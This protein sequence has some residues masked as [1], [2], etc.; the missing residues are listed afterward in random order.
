M[1]HDAFF[2]VA[3]DNA[4][5]TIAERVQGRW[6]AILDSGDLVLPG[7]ALRKMRWCEAAC[8]GSRPISPRAQVW[9]KLKQCEA[10]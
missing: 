8:G 4:E 7:R 5:K 9:A 3:A 1:A 10:R 2:V 6:I